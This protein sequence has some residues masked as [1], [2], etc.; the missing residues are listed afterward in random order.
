MDER[1]ECFAWLFAREVDLSSA[2]NKLK[3]HLKLNG[4]TDEALI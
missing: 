4:C 1:S 3:Q 2:N